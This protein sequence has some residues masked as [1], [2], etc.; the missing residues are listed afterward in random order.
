MIDGALCHLLHSLGAGSA[1]FIYRLRRHFMWT[2]WC[3]PEEHEEERIHL[4]G[5]L[6]P[7]VCALSEI[8][9]CYLSTKTAGPRILH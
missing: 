7:W 6:M 5:V 1:L 8:M 2:S 9:F 4:P 3:W